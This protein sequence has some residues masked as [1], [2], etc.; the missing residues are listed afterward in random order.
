MGYEG[1]KYATSPMLF[2]VFIVTRFYR[3]NWLFRKEL[4]L[5]QFSFQT[6]IRLT[7]TAYLAIVTLTIPVACCRGGISRQHNGGEFYAKTTGLYLDRTTGGNRDY[8]DIGS[9]TAAFTGPRARGGAT[10]IVPKQSEA[11]GSR[12]QDVRQ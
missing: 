4:F 8:C 10:R 3:I 6:S 9:N 5:A 12:I 7:R 11:D 1:T 2:N